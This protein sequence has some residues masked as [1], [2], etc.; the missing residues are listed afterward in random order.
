MS[1]PED[2]PEYHNEGVYHHGT[3]KAV[4]NNKTALVERQKDNNRMMMMWRW[5]YKNS[6]V[7]QKNCKE[8]NFPGRVALILMTVV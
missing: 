7:V 3:A 5:L 6:V 2:G 4:V 1:L 8:R